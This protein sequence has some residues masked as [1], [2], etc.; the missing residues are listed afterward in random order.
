MKNNV[1]ILILATLILALIFGCGNENATKVNEK[2]D[3]FEKSFPLKSIEYNCSDIDF[4]VSQ[5]GIEEKHKLEYSSMEEAEWKLINSLE[6]CENAPLA[7]N[8]FYV[9][10]KIV[11]SDSSSMSY[12]FNNL[13]DY[14]NSECDKDDMHKEFEIASSQDGKLR[15]Y[16]MDIFAGSCGDYRVLVQYRWNG[17][18]KYKEFQTDEISYELHGAF[19]NIYDINSGGETYYLVNTYSRGLHD[20]Y[21][22][23]K[24]FVLTEDGLKPIKLFKNTEGLFDEIQ[25]YYIL[26][27]VVKE[28]DG[29]VYKY[30]EL[31]DDGCISIYL[32]LYSEEYERS[33]RYCKYIWDGKY[34]VEQDGQTFSN[35]LL[36][37]QL[38]DYEIMCGEF[39]TERNLI[40][41]YLMSDGTFRYVAW[42]S[43]DKISDAP[44]LVVNNG[45]K[46][47]DDSYYIFN[48][49]GYEYKVGVGEVVVTKDKKVIGR[50]EYYRIY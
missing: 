37:K 32:G 3:E 39:R 49:D 25:S 48:N 31:S 2:T 16:S 19:P 33:D 9:L 7:E 14:C 38:Q 30:D 40:R 8:I 43:G 5:S 20:Y 6:P 27:I 23:C 4:Y 24:S 17:Q 22:G 44:D 50:W 29:K 15:I 47:K 41:V 28:K 46:S 1:I 11:M 42:K 35:P 12:S 36:Y 34:F 45:Y 13:C 10:K 26:P 21:D 18:L